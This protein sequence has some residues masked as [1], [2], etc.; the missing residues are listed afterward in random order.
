MFYGTVHC[1]IDYFDFS[2]LTV[3]IFIRLSFKISFSFFTSTVDYLFLF[4]PGNLTLFF[5]NFI[6]T[7]GLNRS[8][9]TVQ[10][11]ISIIPF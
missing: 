8:H 6:M 5:F 2:L 11:I 10:S 9:G 7:D 4:G 1:K 3:L